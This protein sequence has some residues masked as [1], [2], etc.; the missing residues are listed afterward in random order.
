MLTIQQELEILALKEAGIT[1]REAERKSKYSR[2]TISAVW[3]RGHVRVRRQKNKGNRRAKMGRCDVCRRKVAMPCLVCRV[4]KLLK[5][6]RRNWAIV[7]RDAPGE[8]FT[9][10][11]LLPDDLARYEELRRDILSRGGRKVD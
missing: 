10:P 11:D 9:G 6:T 4:R 2:N 8:P 5:K 1:V 3:K 7:D